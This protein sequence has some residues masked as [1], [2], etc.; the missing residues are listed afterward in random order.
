[1]NTLNQILSGIRQVMG[2]TSSVRNTAQS[3]S[4][5]TKNVPTFVKNRKEKKEAEKSNYQN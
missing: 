1:M 5:E 3:V 4:R 2:F